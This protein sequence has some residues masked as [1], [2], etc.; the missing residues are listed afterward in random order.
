MGWGRKKTCELLRAS[1]AFHPRMPDFKTHARG[2]TLHLMV[3]KAQDLDA[4]LREKSVSFFIAGALIRE[5][6]ATAIGLHGQP[7]RDAKEIEEVNAARMLATKLE[8]SK[9]AVAQQSPEA[10]FRISGFASQVTGEFS[11]L[12]RAVP[13]LPPHP[14]PLPRGGE[15]SGRRHFTLTGHSRGLLNFYAF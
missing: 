1:S 6:V 13:A 8:C 15:G 4:L 11:G 14:D 10:L 12:G 3:P 2:F 5:A 7:G 9:P